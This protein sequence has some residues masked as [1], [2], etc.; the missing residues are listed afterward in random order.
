MQF[1]NNQEVH[2]T[3][4]CTA[5]QWT[6]LPRKHFF[7]IFKHYPEWNWE[8]LSQDYWES[9]FIHLDYDLL[10]GS[11]PLQP[12]SSHTLSVSPED[13]SSADVLQSDDPLPKRHKLCST[14]GDLLP[15]APL[16]TRP[17]QHLRGS[18]GKN[19]ATC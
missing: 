14:Q 17:K 19:V 3:C 2:P 10:N 11:S 8:K 15:E 6:R 7:A 4:E 9:P 13:I 16:S 12:S 5:W 1:R 18:E